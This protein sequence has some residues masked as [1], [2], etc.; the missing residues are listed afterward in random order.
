MN[1]QAR[2][3]G[4]FDGRTETVTTHRTEPV[5]PPCE[6]P[7]CSNVCEE[8]LQRGLPTRC[9]RMHGNG[10][11]LPAGKQQRTRQG[12]GEQ[13]MSRFPFLSAATETAATSS[14]NSPGGTERL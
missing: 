4:Y 13:V 10:G 11:Y 9:P 7:F 8:A 3:G 2:N 5:I 1:R 6:G 14:A 12:A